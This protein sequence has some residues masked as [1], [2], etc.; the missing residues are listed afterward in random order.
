MKVLLASKSPRRKD[1]LSEIIGSNFAVEAVDVDE[2]LIYDTPEKT[3]IELALLKLSAVKNKDYYDLIIVGDT[4]VWLDG[5]RFGK[6]ND[7]EDAK[8]MLKNL[9]NREHKIVSSI[10]VSYRGKVVADFCVSVLKFKDLSNEDIEQYVKEHNSL[11]KAGAYAVQDRVLVDY[12]KGSY[13]N[14]VGLPKETLIK[15][16]KELGLEGMIISK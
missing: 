1:I 5:I 3:A 4:L 7:I 16:L 8:R 2:S 12:Y 13:S 14:I 9:S 11:D 6:P 10:A 15:I